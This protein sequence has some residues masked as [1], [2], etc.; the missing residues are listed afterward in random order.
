[1]S[2]DNPRS[3]EATVLSAA[4]RFPPNEIISLLDVNRTHNLAESTARNLHFGELVELLGGFE[5]LRDI[6]L[7]YGSSAGLPALREVL[8]V[9]CGIAADKIV[10]TQGTSLALF[11]LAFELCRAGDEVVLATPCFPPSRDTFGACGVA[12]R[13]VSLRF[14]DGYRLDPARLAQAMTARTRLVSIASPQNPS[15]VSVDEA[16]LRAL[17]DRMSERAPR[18][19]LLVDET[20][21]EATYGGAPVPPSAAGLDPRVIVVSSVSKAHGA[22]G[23]RVG[24]LT[25]HDAALRERLIVAKLNTV[26]SGAIL[27]EVLAAGLL[28][29]RDAV[30]AP[31]RQQLGRALELLAQWCAGERGR[32]DW[33]RPDGGALCCVRLR[34]DVF[35]VHTVERFWAL[36]PAHELQLAAGS[37][38]GDAEGRRVFRLGF[39]FLPEA[40]LA[41]ALERLSIAMDAAL[42]G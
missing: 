27:D 33:V 21:R 18:A 23:L 30:L 14:D 29:R 11:L 42:I 3:D 41:P 4:A 10:T 26:I 39:G 40:S 15:G 22:P 25:T 34:P 20:Y 37:W 17:L 36:L 12:T 38:F 16:T 32:I 5:A 24:W 31:R 13:E 28:Q 1:M 7:G 6:E 2:G 35:D 8:G 9:C 19:F